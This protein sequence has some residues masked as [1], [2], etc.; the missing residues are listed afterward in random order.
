MTVKIGFVSLGCNKNLVDTEVMLGLLCEDGFAITSD[1]AEAD[2]LIVNTCAFIDSAKEESINT[3]LE[4]AQYKARRCKLL[5]VAGCLAQRYSDEIRAELPEVDVVVGVGS[6]EEIVR[7]VREGLKGKRETLLAPLDSPQRDHLP[8]LQTTPPYTAYLKI[9]EGCDNRCTYCAIPMIRGRYRS[10]AMDEVLREAQEMVARG[11]KEIIVVA[12][13][14]TRYG[15]DRYGEKRLPELLRGLCAIEGVLWVRVHYC[16][17][18]EIDEALLDVFCAEGK[19]LP[20]FDIPVQH[21]SNR[22]LHRMNRRTTREDL[23]ALIFEIRRRLPDAILRTSLI[24]GFPGETE[25]EF[26]ELCDFCRTVK[27]DRAGVFAY[28]QEEGTPA[29]RLPDQIDE[30]TKARRLE[31]LMEICREASQQQNERRLGT[32]TTVLTEGFAENL[33]VGRSYGESIEVDPSIY[34][35]AEREIAAGET[36]SVRLLAAEDYD[37]FGT[38]D[39][40]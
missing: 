5:V 30:E 4:L 23:E 35:G 12:Q 8:R 18:E 7:A 20:Y 10:R 19:L 29:A 26:L 32:V 13:D 14:T 40:K 31:A 9:A 11:V 17:P 2:V 34:F 38:E 36:V 15:L 25:E 33:Y 22:V 16:Y 3:I 39:V 37:L 28:S 21:A 24:V 6:C 1:P 27:F